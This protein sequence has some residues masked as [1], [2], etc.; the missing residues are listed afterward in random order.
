M[1]GN[2]GNAQSPDAVGLHRKPSFVR[3]GLYDG[4]DSCPG[5]HG[6]IRGQVSYIAGPYSQYVFAQQGE[7]TVH[8][9]LENGCCVYTR[10]IIIAKRRHEGDSSCRNHQVFGVHIE[11]FLG[12]NIFDRQSFIVKYIPDR[13]VQKD[14]FMVFTGQAGCNLKS[15][16]ASE[17]FFLFKKE[18]L[19]GLHVE[20]AANPDIVVNYK[21]GNSLLIKFF[22]DSQACRPCSNDGHNGFIYLDGVGGGNSAAFC[23]ESVGNTL[24]FFNSV[25]F[26]DAY[27]AYLPVN[28]HLTGSAFSYPAGEASVPVVQAVFMDQQSG[29]MQSGRNGKAPLTENCLT[30]K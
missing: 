3:H 27:P 19:M 5:L 7:L 28:Q 20:L 12:F 14:P 23:Q 13:A 17:T 11:D 10:H 15:A 22:P 21:I 26:C 29:L 24:H 30:F 16:H 6:L 18:K 9:P 8:H 1:G 4:P 2:D 25:N